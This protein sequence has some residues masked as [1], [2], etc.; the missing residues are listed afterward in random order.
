MNIGSLNVLHVVTKWALD[1]DECLNEC[2]NTV[3]HN[4][5]HDEH[6]LYYGS[7]RVTIEWQDDENE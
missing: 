6:G 5:P 1:V 2:Y 3:M 4:I 7:F